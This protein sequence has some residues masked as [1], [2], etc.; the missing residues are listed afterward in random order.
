MF[1]LEFLIYRLNFA[2]PGPSL[3]D[4]TFPLC[5]EEGQVQSVLGDLVYGLYV[6]VSRRALLQRGWTLDLS[7]SQ[8]SYGGRLTSLLAPLTLDC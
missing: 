8:G 1:L 7:W 4:P 2:C 3:R 5:C 6:L